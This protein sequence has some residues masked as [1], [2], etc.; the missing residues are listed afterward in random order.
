MTRTVKKSRSRVN[1]A[2]HSMNPDRKASQVDLRGAP[3]ARTSATIRRLQMYRNQ[4]AK[5]DRRGKIVRAA[6]FQSQLPRGSVAR[7]QPNQRWFGNTKVISQSA[8]QQFQKHLADARND[9]YQVVLKPN[10]LPVTLLNERARNKRV[11]ILDNDSFERVFSAKQRQKRAKLSC[12]DLETLVQKADDS[13]QRYRADGDRDLVRDLPDQKDGVS[14]WVMGAGQ[15]RR[16]WNELYKVIDSSDVVVQVLD[17]RDPIGTRSPYVEKFLKKEKAH[18]HLIFVLN[19][20]DLIPTWATQKWVA[21]LSQ[22][23]PTLAFHASVTNPFG[24]GALISLLRQFGKLH[25]DKKQISVGFIGYPNV[26]KSSINNTLKSKKVCKV[27]PLAGETKVWQYITLMRRIYLIDCPGVVYP[28]GETD[29]EKVLKGVVRVELVSSPQDYVDAVLQRVRPAYMCRTYGISEWSDTDDFLEQVAKR[30]GKLLKGGN[31]DVN[32]VSKQIL[33]DFQR[34]KIPFFVPP[35]G[36]ENASEE[37]SGDTVATGQEAH[38]DESVTN[39]VEKRDD[40]SVNNHNENP[41][42]NEKVLVQDLSKVRREHDFS[43]DEDQSIQQ[44]VEL[45]V[46]DG[47]EDAETDHEDSISDVDT[48]GN[49]KEVSLRA[50]DVTECNKEPQSPTNS[51]TFSGHS[52]DD[53]VPLSTFRSQRSMEIEDDSDRVLTKRGTAKERRRE[54]RAK[55]QRKVGRH[56]YTEVDVKNRRKRPRKSS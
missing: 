34:G 27:A 48:S 52:S 32:T 28:S 40:E 22:T 30:T 6:P 9:P 23:T 12:T 41:A 17:A 1:P 7:V 20:V 3:H 46:S 50:D 53:D 51:T 35:P 15:S 43:D 8:L 31:P 10:K 11:H 47:E 21:I 54:E 26:G 18:K 29:T 4:K 38:A 13:Q 56:F 2:G 42:E 14:D 45:F 16:I 49:D 5:R 55:K 25:I 44:S 33:N 39:D 36:S 37:V 19:K 24:K